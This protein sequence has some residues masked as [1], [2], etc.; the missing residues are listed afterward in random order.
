MCFPAGAGAEG[1]P[2]LKGHAFFDGEGEARACLCLRHAHG[3]HVLATTVLHCA[4]IAWAELRS[5]PAPELASGPAETDDDAP[6]WEWTSLAAA[7][8]VYYTYDK[9]SDSATSLAFRP[10]ATT[11]PDA[12]KGSRTAAQLLGQGSKVAGHPGSS[13]SFAATP[14]DRGGAAPAAPATSTGTPPEGPVTAAE[15]RLQLPVADAA[16]AP[17]AAVTL[18]PAP[19]ARSH[20]VPIKSTEPHHASPR[21][22]ARPQAHLTASSAQKSVHRSGDRGTGSS[23]PSVAPVTSS[24][25]ANISQEEEEVEGAMLMH[26]TGSAALATSPQGSGAVPESW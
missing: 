21:V 25:G 14:A 12:A 7:L 4:G 8:P 26:Q 20:S 1:L 19:H 6:D 5:Q 13:S 10:G 22:P 2:K 18:Q 17:A 9:T 11:G 16:T 3:F 24:N 15:A 23:T